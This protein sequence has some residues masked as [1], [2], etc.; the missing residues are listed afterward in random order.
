MNA[1]K[2]QDHGNKGTR[3]EEE[4]EITT[5]ASA[6]RA[7][8]QQQKSHKSKGWITY[9]L[10]ALMQLP[11]A[12]P[13]SILRWT[14]PEGPMPCIIDL[15]SRDKGRCIKIYLWL[16]SLGLGS[17]TGIRRPCLIDFH[18][19]GFIMGG[20]LEQAPWCSS[21]ARAGIIAISVHYR[22]GP[23]WEF[24]AALLDA[25]DVLNAILDADGRTESGKF[26]R[27]ELLRLSDGQTEID[28][29]RIGISGF[30]SGG[31]IALNMLLSIPAYLNTS[32]AAEEEN[33]ESS[34]G[35]A[36]NEDWPSPF[37]NLQSPLQSIPTILFFPSLDA[38]QA[39][40][41]RKRPEGMAPQGEVSKWVGRT[42]LNAYLPQEFV[43]HLR[44]SPGLAPIGLPGG[45]KEEIDVR[46]GAAKQLGL[47]ATGNQG[48]TSQQRVS[49]VV[50]HAT[51]D[52]MHPST[53]ALLI[54]PQIDTLSEQSEIWVEALDAAE[55]LTISP[56]LDGSKIGEPLILNGKQASM[57]HV[58]VHRIEKMSHGFT[59]FPDSFLD[60]KSKVAKKMVMD[61]ALIYVTAMFKQKS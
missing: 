57:G 1:K 59:T 55:K 6:N 42:L 41:D 51:L 56:E 10:S 48:T 38:R 21:L 49:A 46:E 54:L 44:A 2:G 47:P 32:T 23:T 7:T 3:G 17:F 4:E 52:C 5:V 61:Q 50:K 36:A 45:M 27:N 34:G 13:T 39:P 29:T 9:G 20:P 60:E 37:V 40:F 26:I 35:E 25:E 12:T 18:G 11:N 43:S 22:L 8:L 24:P 33:D 53:R 31:N 28:E 16:P 15:P 30:S 19:G 14:T 58:R